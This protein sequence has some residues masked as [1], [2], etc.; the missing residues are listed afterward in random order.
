MV[1]ILS[2]RVALRSWQLV[3]RAYY[4]Y[5][6]GGARGITEKE[7]DVLIKCDGITDVP[8]SPLLD[9]LTARGLCKPAENGETLT[10]WQRYR[11]CDNRY[12]PAL[13]WA[14]T[15]KCNFNCRHC[16]NAA[17]DAASMSEFTWDQCRD[18][19]LQLDECGVQNVALTGGEPMLHPQFMDIYREFSRRGIMVIDNNIF[20][21]NV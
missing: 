16:F 9:S 10:D 17:D 8:P 18:F 13:N 7:F 4:V 19:I 20:I 21:I 1:C 11:F 12:F 14:V 15:G 5:G 3:P 6:E 2:P